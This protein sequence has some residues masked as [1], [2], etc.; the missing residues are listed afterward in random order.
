MPTLTKRSKSSLPLRQ[1][2]LIREEALLKF[3]R[4]VR[5][6]LREKRLIPLIKDFLAQK[7]E[8]HNDW[9]NHGTTADACLLRLC[10]IARNILSSKDS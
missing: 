8:E 4:I 7:E 10:D 3:K 5:N 9:N 6:I 1:Q 2:R